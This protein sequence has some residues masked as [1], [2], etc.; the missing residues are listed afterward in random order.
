MANGFQSNRGFTVIELLVTMAIFVTLLG[1]VT[2]NLTSAQHKATI[3]TTVETLL[4]D[5]GQQQIKAMIGDTEGRTTSDTYGIHFETTSYTLFHGTY[6]QS[7]ASNFLL[8]VPDTQ[9]ITTEFTND[10]IV[11]E[12]GSGEIASYDE[13]N[14]TITVED[15]TTGEQKVIELNRYGVVVGLN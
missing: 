1:L 15:I 11:F 2:M 10:A 12:Q 6:S 4:A 5:L 14:D 7:Q 3:A 8:D 13:N 9:E